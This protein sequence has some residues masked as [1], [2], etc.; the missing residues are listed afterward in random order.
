MFGHSKWKNIMHKKEKTDVCLRIIRLE[1]QVMKKVIC[2]F[3]GIILSLCIVSC[4]SV[5]NG[6]SAEISGDYSESESSEAVNESSESVDPEPEESSEN[7]IVDHGNDEPV[8]LY[9][10]IERT[11]VLAG[12][13]N[14][15]TGFIGLSEYEFGG[16]PYECLLTAALENFGNTSHSLENGLISVGDD[17][18][19][20]TDG[21]VNTVKCTDLVLYYYRD[22]IPVIE[23]KTDGD[24]AK[25]SFAFRHDSVKK[26]A[27]PSENANSMKYDMDNDGAE[28]TL[29]W[30]LD[31][32]IETEYEYTIVP[33]LRL[34]TN[35]GNIE[36]KL[37]QILK[38]DPSRIE[39]IGICDFDSDGTMEII[40]NTVDLNEGLHICALKNGQLEVVF[41]YY[42]VE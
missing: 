40:V 9:S 33:V 39:V 27:F 24:V 30:E 10:H 14:E 12:G 42:I 15:K 37:E 26:Y 5:S 41:D 38:A 22:E 3:I 6:S 28:D 16:E 34:Y 20:Y 18:D 2:F 23:I 36:C 8:I 35:A 19:I 4:E 1:A 7:V 29:T 31:A 17:I 32:D 11:L 13:Y 21:G 25:P